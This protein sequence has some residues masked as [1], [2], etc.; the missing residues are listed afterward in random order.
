[1]SQ[2]LHHIKHSLLAFVLL[3]VYSSSV[4][5]LT[6]LGNGELF[7]EGRAE[8]SYDSNLFI[9]EADKLDDFATV[10][11][12]SLGFVQKQRSVL[13]AQVQLGR[14]FI[15]YFDFSDQTPKI[16]NPNFRSLG[17]IILS[18]MSSLSLLEAGT[19]VQMQ[20]PNW[21]AAFRLRTLI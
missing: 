6:Q 11:F 14:E 19:S 15:R 8:V 3:A 13:N 12:A 17:L 16:G 21:G 9:R 10:Y 20:T 7:I 2:S 18:L 4:Y 1:M 5:G